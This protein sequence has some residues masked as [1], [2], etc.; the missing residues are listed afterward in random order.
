MLSQVP[1]L[2]GD[3][4]YD[5]H[6]FP[7]DQYDRHGQQLDARSH[8]SWVMKLEDIAIPELLEVQLINA[9]AP[10]IL[11]SQL[12]QLMTRDR[13]RSGYI[14][15]VSAI[16]GRFAGVKLTYHPHTNMAK[17]ALNMLT[18]TSAPDFAREKIY[19]NSVDPG[20][21]SLQNPQ[22]RPV[23]EEVVPLDEEDAAARICDPI[24]TGLATGHNEYGKFF[25]D[26]AVTDW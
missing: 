7:P 18:Y 23:P 12:K 8:N 1:M 22:N 26:Y 2:P 17:A 21:I 25:K 10:T 11:I 24:F 13:V 19:M 14:V 15:N 6:A 20:W 3:E 4:R 16:E 9:I 5:V